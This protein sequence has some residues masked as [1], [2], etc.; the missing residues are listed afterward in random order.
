MGAKLAT[1]GTLIDHVIEVIEGQIRVDPVL[2]V[3]TDTRNLVIGLGRFIGK[4]QGA[5][6]HQYTIVATTP[7]K[8]KF[9]SYEYIERLAET[10]PDRF[11]IIMQKLARLSLNQASNMVHG[12]TLTDECLQNVNTKQLAIKQE[13]SDKLK[14]EATTLTSISTTYSKQAGE[15]IVN[16]G[17]P[18]RVALI[19]ADGKVSLLSP[20]GDLLKH[21]MPGDTIGFANL[22][23][24]IFPWQFSLYAAEPSTI[25]AVDRDKLQRQTPTDAG[26]LIRTFTT[27]ACE[28]LGHRILYPVVEKRIPLSAMGPTLP[29]LESV[30]VP[31]SPVLTKPASVLVEPPGKAAQPPKLSAEDAALVIESQQMMIAYLQWQLELARAER[32]KLVE[33]KLSS[34]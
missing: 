1:R 7:V 4:P 18:A 27:L 9:V 34:E 24:S 26:K 8:A 23:G 28:E 17:S 14:I 11:L 29:Q 20:N 5:H 2:S 33:D 32:N 3:P 30:F 6:I 19:I 21:L 22:I 15:C 25:T 31:E 12:V 10:D 13:I 16:C